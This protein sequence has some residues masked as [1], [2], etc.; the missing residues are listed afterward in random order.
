MTFPTHFGEHNRTHEKNIKN[1][2]SKL[3]RKWGG[4]AKIFTNKKEHHIAFLLPTMPIHTEYSTASFSSTHVCKT[5]GRIVKGLGWDAL[6]GS[7][8]QECNT[9][10]DTTC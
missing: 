3:P 6:L 7:S 1:D 8:N 9:K 10:R 2:C 4:G 5:H